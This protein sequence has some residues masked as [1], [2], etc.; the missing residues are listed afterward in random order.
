MGPAR[1][2]H[3]SGSEQDSDERLMVRYADGDPASFEILFDRYEARAYAYFLK[4]TRSADRAN[5]LF[6]ELF[7]RIHRSRDRFDPS[8]S[9][10]AWFFQIAHRLVL[11]EH[12][13]AQRRRESP[14]CGRD[15]IERAIGGV[16]T[17]LD[18]IDV[19][20]LLGE[21]TI[22]ER[23]VVVASQLAGV[24]Y[25]ELARQ[26]DRSTVAVRQMASRAIRR[27]RRGVADANRLRAMTT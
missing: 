6:Q 21:L 27:L 26:L 16:A 11:D 9:F 4:H 22:E 3:G 5:D 25:A 12:R 14:A 10:P 13:R 1:D 2:A 17:E 24:G 15:G 20:S 7:L 19:A 23:M 8:H 18:R